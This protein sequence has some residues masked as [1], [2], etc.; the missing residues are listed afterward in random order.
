MID[1]RAKEDIRKRTELFELCAALGLEPKNKVARCPGHNDTGRPNL[2]IYDDHV[3]CYVCGFHA[4]AFDLVAKVRGFDFVASFDFLAARLGL[5]QAGDSAKSPAKGRGLGYGKK[6]KPSDPY[7]NPAAPLPDTP[8]PTLGPKLPDPEEPPADPEGLGY[9]D[10]GDW[11][12]VYPNKPPL[13]ADFWRDFPTFGEAFAYGRGFVDRFQIVTGKAG[14]CFAVRGETW[15]GSPP[16]VGKEPP[17]SSTKPLR[18]RVFAALLS[19]GRRAS[20]TEAGEWLRVEKAIHP[21][22]QDRAGLVYLDDPRV[23]AA[24]LVDDFGLDAL[25]DLGIYAISKKT[26]KPYFVFL[27]HRL[28]FP[29]FWR[30]EPVDVQGRDHKATDKHDRFRNTASKNPLPYNADDLLAA[31]EAKGPVFLCEGATDTL[32]LAQSGRFAVGIVGTGGFKTAWLPAFDGLD[33]F[34]AFDGDDAGRAAAKKV[35]K[36]FVD[37]GHPAPKTVKLPSGAKDVNELL[38]S[39][40]I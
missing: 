25:V 8:S 40:A 31:R 34:L 17:S 7:P 1:D 3:H 22:T 10:G 26:D 21:A 24:A 27:Y 6:G 2:A 35:T 23:A 29:F 11:S 39:M 9:I 4:D 18:V 38:R 30:G 13:P 32:T 37:A 15:R 20:E 16:T 33:V 28:L 12:K 36:V 5:P 14:D 19:L